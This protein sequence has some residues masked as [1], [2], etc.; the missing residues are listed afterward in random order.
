LTNLKLD[1]HTHCFEALRA[2]PNKDSVKEILDA[3][4]TKG[5][6]GIAITE[7]NNKDY[8][9][10]AL[11][12]QHTYF[13]NEV[14]LIPGQELTTPEASFIELYLPNNVTFR[15]IAHPY[16]Q[17]F[18][19]DYGDIHGIEIDNDM[20][21][22]HI[23]KELVESVAQEHNLLLLYNSDAHYLDDI[24]KF[25]NE[26]AWENFFTKTYKF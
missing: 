11:E 10:R 18:I 1:L 19:K 17:F 16:Y 14:L 24:G 3:V 22:Y 8:G 15:F 4:K 20:H 23:D 12:I 6:D 26:L 9:F 7:H 13:G 5:L 2:K 21:N 25:Y